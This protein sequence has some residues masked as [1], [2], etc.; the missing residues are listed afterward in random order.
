MFLQ[1]AVSAYYDS[2]W[3][4]TRTHFL[5]GWA[6]P[7]LQKRNNLLNRIFII[8]ERM[9]LCLTN[10]KFKEKPVSPLLSYYNK[11]KHSWLYRFAR[12]RAMLILYQ[13][14]SDSR[15]K[16]RIAFLVHKDI[17]QCHSNLNLRRYK[18][19]NAR[20]ICFRKSLAFC[21]E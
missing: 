7:P 1:C 21:R 8:R 4:V 11:N 5:K 6:S 9:T 20:A 12:Y 17:A 2:F 16:K 13:R 10:A 19:F 14:K 15:R 18:K 3:L